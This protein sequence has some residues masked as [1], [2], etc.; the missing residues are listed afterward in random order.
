[1]TTLMELL[2]NEERA[3]YNF[4]KKKI[5]NAQTKVSVK[6][7]E[8]R[9]L[10]VLEKAKDRIRSEHRDVKKDNALSHG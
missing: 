7:Y 4:L 5:E 3:K 1:M 2:N 10:R 9:A 6:Y 8:W